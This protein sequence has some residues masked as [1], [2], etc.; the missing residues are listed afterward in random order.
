MSIKNIICAKGSNDVNDGH[1]IEAAGTPETQ[2]E[3]AT[4]LII[5]RL[6]VIDM[7]QTKKISKHDTI[8]TLPERK[9]L[10]E[11]LFDNVEVWDGQIG[12]DIVAG[13]FY[14]K[15]PYKP[16]YNNYERDKELIF[17]ISYNNN[18]LNSDIGNFLICIPRLKNSDTRRNLP[19]DEWKNFI[20]H[21]KTNFDKVLVFGKGNEL[22]DNGNDILYVDTLQDYCSYLHHKNCK[23]VVSTISGPCHYVQQFGNVDGKCVMT[24]IDNHGLIK[25]YHKDPSYFHSC[26]N[27]TD[28]T[29]NYINDIKHLK[30]QKW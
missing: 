22:L 1:G 19:Q 15:L 10:Y 16:F 30:E 18:I 12:I 20:N 4:E 6:A 26:I 11:N 3:A 17:N 7:L 23:H 24:M 14:N 2:T 27:F 9:F 21:V 8:I 5:N 28:V 13:K 25:T 29:I